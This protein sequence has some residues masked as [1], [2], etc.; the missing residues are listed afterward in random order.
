LAYQ[1]AKRA[2]EVNPKSA[3]GWMNL[4]RIADEFYR[5]DEAERAFAKALKL[6][7]ND[8]QRGT[9][10]INLSAALVNKGDWAKGAQA[11]KTGLQFKPESKKLKAN[12]GMANLGLGLWSGGWKNYDEIIAFDTSRA[13]VKYAEEPDWD[14]RPG[15]RVVV[16]GEQGLGDEISFASMIPDLADISQKVYVDCDRRLEGLF[17]RSFPDCEVH[18][19]RWDREIDWLPEID[20]STTMGG[21]GKFFRTKDSQFPRKPYLIADPERVEMWRGLFD[22]IKKPVIGVSWSG[23]LFWTAGRFRAMT[24][25]DLLPIFQS[26]DAVWVSLQYKDASEEIQEFK[27]RHPEIDLRQYAWATLTNDYDDTA[28]LVAAL[29]KVVSMQQSVIHLAGGLGKETHVFVNKHSQW[30]Y[31]RD[32][33]LWYPNVKL[34][35][36]RQDGTYPVKEVARA[37][38]A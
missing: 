14:G 26:L 23:G 7:K 28:G 3:Y 9:V 12:L 10:Y 18:G 27:S 32:E 5:F 15:Q 38:S 31:G 37:L 36:Q 13:R 22:K 24:L 1:F 30:R 16:Y 4:G 19:T 20:A 25:E 21:L 2:V 8:D 6:C 11:A 17:Q 33:M 34:Y 35:R 29:D